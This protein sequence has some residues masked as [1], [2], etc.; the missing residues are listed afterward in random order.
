MNGQKFFND[1][2]ELVRISIYA[3]S[4]KSLANLAE[5]VQTD[6]GS[7]PLE[8]SNVAREFPGPAPKG[9]ETREP[10]R[11]APRSWASLRR[12]GFALDG[13]D[14]GFS[15]VFRR[16]VLEKLTA[17]HSAGELPVP[18]RSICA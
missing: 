17:A 14:L 15:R 9:T 3:K 1:F 5:T 8:P 12:S 6:P 10:A 4:L 7:R 16:L 2:S 18:T 13:G 11:G